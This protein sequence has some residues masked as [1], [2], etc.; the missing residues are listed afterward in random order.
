ME[1]TLRRTRCVVQHRPGQRRNL[2]RVQGRG[3][4]PR[5]R[6]N[7]RFVGRPRCS[8]ADDNA[9]VDGSRLKEDDPDDAAL[10]FVARFGERTARTDKDA[11]LFQC[12][13]DGRVR[14]RLADLNV[15][16]REFPSHDSQPLLSHHQHPISDGGATEGRQPLREGDA[17]A[18]VLVDVDTR[19]SSMAH[20]HRHERALVGG[21]S[22]REQPGHAH[23]ASR[24]REL[25]MGT[26]TRPATHE[27]YEFPSDLAGEGRRIPAPE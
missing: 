27:C 18:S 22:E 8:V 6:S 24:C 12:F 10:P 16:A 13:S 21:R 23:T 11:R 17:H 3:I 1:G 4:H 26:E 7:G 14:D 5:D 2:A 20:G 19:R 9:R 15:T 25:G